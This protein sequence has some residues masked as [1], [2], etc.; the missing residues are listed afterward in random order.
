[1]L[2]PLI[3]A[4]RILQAAAQATDSSA[5]VRLIVERIRTT[6]DVDVCSL[7]VMNED[8]EL[9]LTATQGLAQ[10]AIGQIR[11]TPGQGLVGTIAKRQ[12]PL[13]LDHADKHPAFRYFKETGEEHYQGFLGVPMI[14]LG[15]TLGVLVVQVRETRR[16]TEEEEAFLITMAAHLAGSLGGNIKKSVRPIDPNQNQQLPVTRFQGIKGAPGIE[17]APAWVVKDDIRLDDIAERSGSGEAVERRRIA[18]AVAETREELDS[19]LD[20]L[21]N[22]ANDTLNSL[23]DVYKLLLD[24]PE[25]STAIEAQIAT[26]VSASTALKHAFQQQIDVFEAMADPYLKAR[27]E[28]LRVLAIRIYRRLQDDLNERIDPEQPVILVGREINI[29]HFTRIDR[30]KLAGI[31]SLEG[32]AL[33]HTAVLANALGIPAVVGIGDEDLTSV[34]GSEIILDGYR[35]QVI[36][37]APASLVAEFERMKRQQKA[38]QADLSHLKKLPAESKDG[39]TVQ[40]HTNT[41]L[42]AD[43]TPGL[44]R[45]AEGVGLYRSEIPF[46]VHNNFPTEEEQLRIYQGVLEAYAPKPVTMRTLDIGGDKALPYFP[47]QEQ[48][49]FLGW[50]GIRFTLDYRNILL[51]QI[52]AMLLANLNTQNLKLMIPMLSREDELLQFHAIVD[53]AVSQLNEEGHAVAKPPVGIMVEVPAVLWLLPRLRDNIDFVSIGSN[54]LTQYLLAVDRNNPRVA[55]LYSHLH[56]AVLDALQGLVRECRRLNLPVSICGEMASDPAAVILLLGM[57]IRTLSLSAFHLPRI[58]WLIRHLHL[59]DCVALLDKSRDCSTEAERREMLNAHIR[60]LGLGA[61]VQ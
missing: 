49:P 45:G 4:K 56:S 37:H 26:G 42:L 6:L 41:G 43:I 16:F 19:G 24:S 39:T 46:M 22:S 35:G 23:L 27:A 40:L 55:S 57:G 12:H 2:N 15:H 58:K 17:I 28:D 50:R 34:N 18:E 10:E 5:L 59:N 48:N 29:S 11:M 44:E 52:R 9:V 60:S 20:Q 14:H 25:L 8:G 31:V 32:S 3:T 1:M 51:D 33:S 7:Y 53:E 30:S 36:A 61:L 21:G 47:I 38:L 13:N 54:D